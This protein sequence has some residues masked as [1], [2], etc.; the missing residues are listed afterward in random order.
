MA[1]HVWFIDSTQKSV[2]SHISRYFPTSMEVG[3]Y[4]LFCGVLNTLLMGVSLSLIL[5]SHYPSSF[6]TART[7]TTRAST[8]VLARVLLSLSSRPRG[9]TGHERAHR[10]SLVSFSLSLQ[11]HADARDTS[12]H[13]SARSCP[14]LSLFKTTQTH[15]TRASTSVLARA[16]IS[17]SST[18]RGRTGHERAHRCSPVSCMSLS[19]SLRR[20]GDIEDTSEHISAHSCPCLFL[21]DTARTHRTRA[22]T[23]VL[24]R[25]LYV[26]IP[27]PS[28]PWGHRGHE[29]ALMCSLVS[30]SLSSR[31]RGRTGHERAYRCSPVSC[32]S[33]S[34]LS[35][36]WGHRG[37]ERA[38]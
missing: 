31:P 14:S 30:S 26:L 15:G 34:V 17:L 27:L 28:T 16:L 29:R 19:L 32:M 24:A 37:H 1:D 4:Q 9:R 8:L 20:H 38:H 3:K 11:D 22:S 7:P 10:C 6:D 13:I 25:V 33:L 23:S 12:E 2:S 35:T 18:P 36:P 21:F 5:I